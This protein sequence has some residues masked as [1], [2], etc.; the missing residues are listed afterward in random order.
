MSTTD[1]NMAINANPQARLGPTRAVSF[2]LLVALSLAGGAI[3]KTTVTAAP[4]RQELTA[5]ADMPAPWNESTAVEYDSQAKAMRFEWESTEGTKTA[6]VADS[7]NCSSQP[8]LQNFIRN[9]IFSEREARKAD[10]L[11]LRNLVQEVRSHNP[12]ARGKTIV[13]LDVQFRAVKN[14]PT[15]ANVADQEIT[16]SGKFSEGRIID[17]D[18]ADKV[19]RA[20]CK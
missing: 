18:D 2:G 13:P 7:A 1:Q 16:A 10:C 20:D 4:N 5:C 12:N 17:L 9:S 14:N 19:L 11:D 6:V 8:G 3:L 15:M